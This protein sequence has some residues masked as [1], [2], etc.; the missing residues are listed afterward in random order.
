CAS[1]CERQRP[2]DGLRRLLLRSKHCCTG[3]LC[4]RHRDLRLCCLSRHNHNLSP[5]RNLH[6]P[7]LHVRDIRPLA[8]DHRIR[9]HYHVHDGRHIHHPCRILDVYRVWIS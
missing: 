7:C 3:D 4:H 5:G 8:L 1:P 6:R 9:C 2:C